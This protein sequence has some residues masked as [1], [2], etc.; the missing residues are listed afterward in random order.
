MSGYL[1]YI[2][3]KQQP[4]CLGDQIKP[5]VLDVLVHG[6]DLLCPLAV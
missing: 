2:C 1:A 6:L 3:Q 5:V 4:V